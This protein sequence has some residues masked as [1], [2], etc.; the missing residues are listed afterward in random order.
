MARNARDQIRIL[1]DKLGV[2]PSKSLGQ[3]FLVDATLAEWIADQLGAEAEDTVV[4]IGPGTGALSAFL[5]GRTRQLLLMEFDRKLAAFLREEYAAMEGVEVIEADAAQFDVRTLFKDGPIKLIGNLPYSAG[6]EIMRTFLEY[7]SPVGEALFMLQTEVA[8]RIC[9]APRTKS[10]GVLTLRIQSR[11]VPR[12]VRSVP[13]DPFYPRP[14]VGSSILKLTPRAPR[15]TGVFSQRIFD[16]LIRRGFAQRRKQLKKMIGGDAPAPWETICEQ[17]EV[18]ATVRAEELS[19]NQWI[20]LA[21]LY[22]PHPLK[23]VAQRDDEMFDVV[24]ESNVVIRQEKRSVVHAAGLRHRAVHILVLNAKG[25]IFLQKRSHLKDA[26]PDLWD[27]SAAGHLDAGESYEACA[28][29]ELD[30]ELGIK[31]GKVRKIGGISAREET[32]WEFVELFESSHDGPFDYPASEISGGRFF[33]P[34]ELE[35]W[36]DSRPEDFAP[37]L[38]ECFR[39]WNTTA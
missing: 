30:E 37:G 4:E 19:L 28:I 11:W 25:E 32:G 36:I 23:A 27:S 39:L 6:G 14:T 16:Q 34:T 2:V 7:P 17:L 26:C 24:D 20:A 12:I 3:N 18:P 38:I 22:D 33:S 31:D 29:R 15:E 9:S 1:L 8:E 21:N 5:A 10:Y 13:A 35:A